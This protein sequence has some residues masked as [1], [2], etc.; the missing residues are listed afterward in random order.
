MAP[1][2]RL[3]T[4]ESA[5]PNCLPMMGSDQIKKPTFSKSLLRFV[6]VAF[7]VR[8]AVG[9]G[10]LRVCLVVVRPAVMANLVNVREIRQAICVH[11]R[12][13]VLS[14]AG[15]RDTHGEPARVSGIEQGGREGGG[16][17]TGMRGCGQRHFT[18][19]QGS[20]AALAMDH[21]LR[22]TP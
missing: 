5:S 2:G 22:I 13:A 12:E 3:A 8:V 4:L 18:I 6:S 14:E 20:R 17:G 16:E 11:H 9:V 10:R 21:Q 1:K 7:A 15:V 19:T